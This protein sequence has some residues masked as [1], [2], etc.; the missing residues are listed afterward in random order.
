MRFT[1]CSITISPEYKRLHGS[2]LPV[3]S[4]HR[5]Q[6]PC[7]LAVHPIPSP[8]Q[9]RLLA[10]RCASPSSLVKHVYESCS[11]CQRPRTSASRAP[12]PRGAIRETGCPSGAGRDRTA[13][14]DSRPTRQPTGGPARSVPQKGAD[15][16]PR[17]HAD[18]AWSERRMASRGGPEANGVFIMASICFVSCARTAS[19]EGPEA[20]PGG[21]AVFRAS[22][23]A[24]RPRRP[25]E[26]A[27]LAMNT[28]SGPCFSQRC[29]IPGMDSDTEERKRRKPIAAEGVDAWAGPGRETDSQTGCV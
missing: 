13:S 27:R 25:P 18:T 5:R 20:V 23:P 14:L 1:T 7:I 28:R 6:S 4:S 22:R 17:C 12:G 29:E 2:V 19:R 21:G 8:R 24:S 26:G 9:I 11:V 10:F 16:A 3:L 15:G